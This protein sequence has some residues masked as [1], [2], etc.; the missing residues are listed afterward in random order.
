MDELDL[1]RQQRNVID[2]AVAKTHKPTPAPEDDLAERGQQAEADDRQAATRDADASADD[3]KAAARDQAADARDSR[4]DSRDRYGTEVLPPLFADRRKARSDRDDAAGDRAAAAD[5][6]KRSAGDRD[7]ATEDRETSEQHRGRAGKDRTAAHEAVAQLR[8]LLLNAEDQSENMYE[9]AKAQ[10]MIMAVRGVTG[11]EA[12]LELGLRAAH[13]RSE[14][15][16]AAQSIVQEE[17]AQN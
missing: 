2:S 8:A 3:R 14:L 12:L 4:A 17:F 15:A 6:R 10:G 1:R 5:D 9:I 13:D 11:L 7:R 16:V